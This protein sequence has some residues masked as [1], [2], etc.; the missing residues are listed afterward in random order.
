MVLLLTDCPQFPCEFKR[1]V[2]IRSSSD[3]ISMCG[4]GLWYLQNPCIVI[5][6]NKL[7]FGVVSVV[8]FVPPVLTVLVVI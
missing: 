7:L 6:I 2:P 8:L 1:K 5:L 4:C 3:F